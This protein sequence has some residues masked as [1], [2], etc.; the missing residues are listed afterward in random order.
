MAPRKTCKIPKAPHL[1]DTQPLLGCLAEGVGT[2][3]DAS[4][5]LLPDES[6]HDISLDPRDQSSFP[7]GRSRS[8][9][10]LLHLDRHPHPGMN[11]AL[12]AV[13]TLRQTRNL[14]AAALK[15][16]RPRN[17]EV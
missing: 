9:R 4:P 15:D 5:G 8:G 16:S 3:G 13:F 12:K 6:G 1:P 10:E 7:N 2:W 11:A 17:R 14:P